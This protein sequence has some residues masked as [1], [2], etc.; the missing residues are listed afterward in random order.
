MYEFMRPYAVHAWNNSAC[1]RQ[2]YN[3]TFS[4]TSHLP[5]KTIR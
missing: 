5:V 3:Q 4:E 2:R 1:S